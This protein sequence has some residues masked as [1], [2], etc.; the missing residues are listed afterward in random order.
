MDFV[1]AV[2]FFKVAM[3]Y[4]TGIRY[5]NFILWR[6]PCTIW[7]DDPY[8]CSIFSGALIILVAMASRTNSNNTSF[9]LYLT[10]GNKQ[11]PQSAKLFF[12][13]VQNTN[14]Y[15]FVGFCFVQISR[16]QC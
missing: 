15:T 2:M 4:L 8:V 9:W 10:R 13:Q 16:R 7:S 14:C 5:Q 11:D 12:V 6:F 3:T 1:I